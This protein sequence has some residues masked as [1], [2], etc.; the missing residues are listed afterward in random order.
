MLKENGHQES[1]S[2]KIYKR[3]TNN[4]SLSQS[5]QQ[6][7]ATDI[8]EEEIRTSINL[9]HVEGTS[10]KLRRILKSHKTRPTFYTKST[11]RRLLCKP[12]DRVATEDKSNI[13]YKID[14]SKRP[15]KSRSDEQKRSV[16]N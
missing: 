10:E 9:P 11:L 16:K 15:L 1:I 13:V 3:I 14:C 5:Q 8:Q 12:K 6:L 4:H 7:Q 2:S